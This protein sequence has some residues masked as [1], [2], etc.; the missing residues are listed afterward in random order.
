MDYRWDAGYEHISFLRGVSGKKGKLKMQK[1]G[2]RKAGVLLL[3]VE[4]GYDL[5]EY[6]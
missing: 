2:G 5:H 3:E 1:R 6:N 4:R